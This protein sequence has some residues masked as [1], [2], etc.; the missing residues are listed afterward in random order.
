[1]PKKTYS[2]IDRPTYLIKTKSQRHQ[3]LQLSQTV[4]RQ[5][6]HSK[7][8][9]VGISFKQLKR[10]MFDRKKIEKYKVCVVRDL[11]VFVEG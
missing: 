1:M 9:E 5:Q 10:W 7:A 11:D 8:T 6:L 4:T 2:R 3:L